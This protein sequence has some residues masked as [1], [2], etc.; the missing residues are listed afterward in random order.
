MTRYRRTI[1]VVLVSILAAG[2]GSVGHRI[3]NG[4]AVVHLPPAMTLFVQNAQFL[5]DHASDPDET[6][7]LAEDPALA[8]VR[9]RLEAA[10]REWQEKTA[11]PLLD[12]ARRKRWSEAAKKW[13]ESAPRLQTGPYPDVATVPPGDLDLLKQET[14]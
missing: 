10:L 9:R 1:F 11:D 7:N 12:P 6:K 14:P 3:I 4:S 13:K 2:W 5:A 8:G